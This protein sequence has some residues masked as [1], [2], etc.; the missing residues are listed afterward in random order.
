[1]SYIKV[2]SVINIRAVV[3][4]EFDVELARSCDN[5]ATDKICFSGRSKF[6]R[7]ARLVPASLIDNFIKGKVVQFNIRTNAF[8]DTKE[9]W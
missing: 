6:S 9:N 7:F 8:V 4:K 1:M 2:L 3:T 5:P